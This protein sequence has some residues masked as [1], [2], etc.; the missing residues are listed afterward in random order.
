MYA[1]IHESPSVRSY[2]R[3]SYRMHQSLAENARDSQLHH[4]CTWN[5]P[6]VLGFGRS[7][8]FYRE[9]YGLNDTRFE[10]LGKGTRGSAI[11]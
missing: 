9:E 7:K 6:P 8:R 11:R 2:N 10:T 3:S 5:P 4:L 1:G